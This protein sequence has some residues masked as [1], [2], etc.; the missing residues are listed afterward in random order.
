MERKKR[1]EIEKE[2]LKFFSSLQ[3]RDVSSQPL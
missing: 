2:P 1:K 3:I